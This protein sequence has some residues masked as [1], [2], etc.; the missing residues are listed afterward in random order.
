MHRKLLDVLAD[1]ATGD[2]LTVVD[3]PGDDWIED[4]EL[5]SSSGSRY[6]IVRGIPR[7][8]A[9]G[10][11]ESFGLQWNRFAK[12]Q[13]DS[14]N[15]GSYSKDRFDGELGWS[16][17]DLSGKWV[18]DAGCGSGR[19]AEVAAG[20]GA[21]VIAV[22]LSSAVD[23]CAENLRHLPNVHVVQ[24]DITRLPLRPEEISFLYSIGVIQHTPDPR[25]TARRL[26]EFLPPGARFG[27]TIYGRRPWT[28]LYGKYLLRPVTRRL[29][30]ARLLRL[31]EG[32]MPV[33]FPVTSVLFPLPVVGKVVQFVLPVGNY[34]SQTDLPRSVRYDQAVLDTFD[35]L[36]PRYDQPMT[37]DEVRGAIQDLCGELRF[38]AT[39]PVV[40]H[41][42]RRA[43]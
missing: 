39:R 3:D 20:Y 28:K 19:F 35:M 21:E 26:V 14:R 24:A 5:T 18:V 8:V 36:A 16:T 32:A 30:P 22:D 9:E 25:V 17:T 23:A 38:T 11:T 31:V 29:P 15:G 40:V 12:V 10:Y 43:G 2:R 6:P 41:G 1:P 13:L 37:A 27:F 34:P 33:L 4:G 42:A 7:F